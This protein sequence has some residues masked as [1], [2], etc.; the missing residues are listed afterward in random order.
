M[1]FSI[2]FSI[3]DTW[4]CSLLIP[5]FRIEYFPSVVSAS[6]HRLAWWRLILLDHESMKISIGRLW[7][8]PIS[9][10]SFFPILL[11]LL[12]I[13]HFFLLG[14][15]LRRAGRPRCGSWSDSWSFTP[16]RGEWKFPFLL[17]LILFCFTV[18]RISLRAWHLVTHRSL[19]SRS[20][21]LCLATVALTLP[22]WSANS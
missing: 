2:S 11:S 13:K 19:P 9:L 5:V 12:A 1:S 3:V 15:A 4:F 18:S 20:F 22:L 21:K 14:H 16:R 10:P 17:S 6:D 8:S 7:G